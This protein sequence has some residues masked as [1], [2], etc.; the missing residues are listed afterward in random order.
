MTL[1]TNWKSDYQKYMSEYQ[2]LQDETKKFIENLV[3][4]HVDTIH[5]A[6]IEERAKI[7]SIQSIE[8]NIKNSDKYKTIENLFESNDI[9]GV[10]VVCHCEDDVESLVI[11]LEGE[12]RQNYSNVEVKEIGGRGNEYPYRAKH[13]NFSKL[14]TRSGDK[15]LNFFCEVQLRTVMADAWA[16]QNHKYIYK[17]VIEGEAQELTNA[18]SEIMIGCEKLWSLVKKK[19]QKR[20]PTSTPTE[21]IQIKEKTK[22]QVRQ[23]QHTSSQDI[24]Q[25][26]VVHQEAARKELKKLEIT[27]FMEVKVRLQFPN[28][29][30]TK[31]VLRDAAKE[32]TIPTFGWPIA[33]FLGNR[34]EYKPV[35]D[36]GGIK[37][38]IPIERHE[39]DGSKTFDYWALHTS[40]A[41][42]TL[43]SI[44]E[45]LRNPEIISF[46]TR[47]VR[48]TEVF[49][50]LKKLYTHL[51][52]DSNKEFEIAIKHAGIKG[53]KLGTLSP[54][55]LMFRTYVCA[56]DEIE[57][58]ISTSISEFEEKPTSVVGQFTEPL[59]E[60]FD[61]FQLNGN[62]LEEIVINYLNGKVS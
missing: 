52:I 50:Y 12:L 55:R 29:S 49:M 40:A 26:F 27:T 53:R 31:I 33:V 37:A 16:V 4:K 47:I 28:M 11:L 60:L 36:A 59:F 10:R 32:S 23:I 1:N 17:K 45:D 54:N 25:W 21:I 20:V 58:V 56:Q 13:I 61:F 3:S 9:A 34:D 18:V 39:M 15:P 57:T 30:F 48:I 42:Y 51:G 24:N 19:S 7:K 38:I 41:F 62:V 44:F 14:I 5:V 22:E 46:S 8:Q 6:K 2:F 43:K 35:V